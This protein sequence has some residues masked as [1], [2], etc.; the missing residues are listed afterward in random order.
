MTAY[1]RAFRNIGKNDVAQVGG[2][3]SSLG[4][5]FNQLAKN[6][7]RVPDGFATTAEAYWY[8]LDENRLGDTLP[9]YLSRDRSALS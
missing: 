2:K 1:T 5:M 4:E 3:N 8:F 6:G 7:I 9:A